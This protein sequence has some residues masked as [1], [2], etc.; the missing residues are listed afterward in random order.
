MTKKNVQKVYG[1]YGVTQQFHNL[2]FVFHTLFKEAL[3]DVTLLSWSIFD[4]FLKS[5]VVSDG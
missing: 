1:V 3:H 4:V 5:F 2:S